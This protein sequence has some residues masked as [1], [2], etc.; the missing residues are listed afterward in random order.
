MPF[1]VKKCDI[2]IPILI[3]LAILSVLIWVIGIMYKRHTF[4][5]INDQLRSMI[6]GELA[7]ILTARRLLESNPSPEL[8][9]YLNDY[10]NQAEARIIQLRNQ[11]DLIS[12]GKIH[13]L[14]Q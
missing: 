2:V 9:S 11:I 8:D 13:A 6:E 3:A 10:I 7:S 1:Q 5:T 4:I 12:H 14:A